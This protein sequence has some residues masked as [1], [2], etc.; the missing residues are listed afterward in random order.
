MSDRTGRDVHEDLLRGRELAA[1]RGEAAESHA[2]QCAAC[3]A[4]LAAD[5]LLQARLTEPAGVVSSAFLAETCARAFS[6]G[7]PCAPLW[8][9]ALPTSWRLGLA[10]LLVLAVLGGFHFG[11]GPGLPAC[12]ERTVISVLDSPE[13]AALNAGRAPGP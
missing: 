2:K 6:V 7:R 3:R 10:A 13:L 8:W 12:E 5:A 1:E 4:M 9:A 11:K